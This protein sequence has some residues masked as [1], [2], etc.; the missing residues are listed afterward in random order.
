L[1]PVP[2]F[3]EVTAAEVVEQSSCFSCSMPLQAAQTISENG[4]ETEAN[5]K[6]INCSNLYCLDC[7]EYIHT[8]LHSCPGCEAL[9]E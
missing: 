4:K 8:Y 1:F 3:K 5:S 2:A 7:D 6:C 9:G